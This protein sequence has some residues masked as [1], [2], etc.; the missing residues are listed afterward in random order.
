M[1]SS[2]DERLAWL[3]RAAKDA[4]R[5]EAIE[6]RLVQLE[7]RAVTWRNVAWVAIVFTVLGAWRSFKG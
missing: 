5:Y 6:K 4:S 2:T 3:E 7:A 1:E